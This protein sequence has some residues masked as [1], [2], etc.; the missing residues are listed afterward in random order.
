MGVALNFL[1]QY[2][3]DGNDEEV[4]IRTDKPL[5]DIVFTLTIN[6]AEHTENVYCAHCYVLYLQKQGIEPLAND[7]MVEVQA[8]KLSGCR[9]DP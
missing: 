4:L 9:F 2:K 7:T 3:E 6:S 8:L 1:T 5:L